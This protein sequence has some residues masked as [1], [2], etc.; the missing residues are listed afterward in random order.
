MTTPQAPGPV[1]VISTALQRVLTQW[2]DNGW[3]HAGL[4]LRIHPAALNAIRADTDAVVRYRRQGQPLEEFLIDRWFGV[5]VQV[6]EEVIPGHL[7][8]LIEPDGPPGQF[9]AHCLLPVGAIDAPGA[10]VPGR[11]DAPG[12]PVPGFRGGHVP[13]RDL[14]PAPAS[15][16][17]GLWQQFDEAP[18]EAARQ[19]Y[20]RH[21]AELTAQPAAGTAAVMRYLM[22]RYG[23][24]E[25]D[26]RAEVAAA[27]GG[28]CDCGR[29]DA[30]LAGD[31]CTPWPPGDGGTDLPGTLTRDALGAVYGTALDVARELLR[32]Q[33][34][35][36]IRVL[37]VHGFDVDALAVVLGEI[38]EL[39]GALALDLD[40]LPDDQVVTV[41]AGPGRIPELW[42]HAAP[43]VWAGPPGA[44]TDN[45]T[46][47]QVTAGQAR[48]L[49]AAAWKRA[50]RKDEP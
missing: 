21:L 12:A 45:P 50:G 46:A 49:A 9:M 32:S 43:G 4:V 31:G 20:Q 17:R 24:A 30:H 18:L 8:E 2:P 29:A 40:G 42:A 11:Y 35:A 44:D 33:L 5:P 26:A 14:P 41:A 25:A 27:A 22:S 16:A 3:Q 6:T 23:T 28:L 47:E 15:T 39:G 37:A 10:P 7:A 36:A 19:V 13:F 34:A 48:E 1:A 38:T